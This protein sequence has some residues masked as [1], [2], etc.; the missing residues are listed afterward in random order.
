[1]YFKRIEMQG[2]KS[3][4]EPVTIEFTDGITCIV[5]PNGSG[6]SNISDAIRWVLGEQSPKMLRG[7]K[8]EEVIFAG[9][10]SRKSRGMAEVTLVIDNSTGILDIDYN[11]VAITRR[12]FRSG[13][14]EYAINNNQCRLRD[15]RNLIMDTG[16]GV[17]GYSII[18]Q[19]KI[20][21]IISDKP[22]SRREIFEEAAGI[23]TYRTKK[24]ESERKLAASQA[25]LE[26]VE[27]IVKELE[28]RIPKLKSDSE[29]AK[30][31]LSL[32]ERYKELEINITLKNV[33]KIE[34]QDE[35]FK[36][37]IAEIEA[38]LEEIRESRLEKEKDAED[39]RLRNETLEGIA[40]ETKDKLIACVESINNAVSRNELN[41]AKID[42]IDASRE[43][44]EGEI[45]AL[46]AK[47]EREKE[48]RGSLE[49]T[50]LDIDAKLEELTAVLTEKSNAHAAL[51][52]EMARAAADADSKK[53]EIFTLNSAVNAKLSEVQSIKNLIQTLDM[54]RGQVENDSREAETLNSGTLSDR[55]E[56]AE[57]RDAAEK[58]LAE[59]AEEG[60]KATDAYNSALNDERTL[61]RE[62]EET[63]LSLGRLSA[64]RKTFEEMEAN[65][66]GYNNAVKYI[67]KSGT[68][69]LRGVVAELITVP[70]G[71]E[72]AIETALGAALQNVVCEDDASAKE[73]ITKLKQNRAGRLTFLPITSVRPSS[74]RDA[75]AVRGSKGFLGFGTECVKYDAKY[76]NVMDYL[77]AR[78]AVVD[79]MDNATA[80]SK[81]NSQGLRIV[82]L[83][84]EVINASGA[85]TGG[86]YKNNTAN[87]LG[88]KAEIAK[89]AA[90]MT[91]LE[92]KRDKSSARAAELRTEME[93]SLAR[94]TELNSEHR[95]TELELVDLKNRLE[96]AELALNDFETAKAKR[97]KEIASI[98]EQKERAGADIER[99][100]AE[101]EEARGRIA[102]TESA[103]G[104]IMAGYDSRK[105]EVEAASEEITGA[106][107]NVSKCE[108]EK[109]SADAMLAR[110]T[111]DINDIEADITSRRN[112]LT[113]LADERS[114]ITD[115]HEDWAA[116]IAEKE[117]ERARIE[118]YSREI[119]EEKA[120]VFAHLTAISAEKEEIDKKVAQ[121]AQ[122]K[123]EIE[124]K[125]AKGEAQ[126]E[127]FKEKLWEEFEISYVQAIEMKKKDFSMSA[128]VKENREIK[129]R[130]REL[131][132]V[133]VG[134]IEEYASVSERYDF[135]TAQRADI[136]EA[137]ASLK[138]IIDDMDRTIISG[139]KTSFEEIQ[140]NFEEIFQ[141][142]FGGGIAKL[143]LEDENDPLGSG[144]EIT[145]QPPGKKLQNINLLS[146][147]EKTMT[148]IALMFAIL[149]T[150]PTP[151]CI[152]DEVE[153]ALD[154]ANIDRFSDY[155]KNFENIQFA[156]VT[157]QKATMAHADVLYG[158][159][160]PEQGISKVLSLR[161]GDEF[162]LN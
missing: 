108:S 107:I 104:A 24:A 126:L 45:E 3:F 43:R 72:V 155:L 79:N 158:V 2:F 105:A 101:A 55:K 128:A 117:E 37:D 162:E 12:M 136:L 44:L 111:A 109:E 56:L 75:A 85:I 100:N 132:E 116:V 14:S 35:Y 38:N 140:T 154:D 26:R 67:M 133:N 18:G 97:E 87:L 113:S 91:E 64:R 90:E 102:E 121:L 156:L 4:A 42:S 134:A 127:T 82:T 86:S 92:A 5:G 47:L 129:N 99:L 161:L 89:I 61:A 119:A 88:R 143:K 125:K 30:E 159:T 23:V 138:K 81:K 27:D 70:E 66:E 11:E 80:L 36:D 57:K 62:L 147:G 71:Y 95:K 139:F 65:Y 7:G 15:I 96:A 157:H 73:A 51:A 135:L 153:A 83:E 22:E 94:A 1:M 53:D 149:K 145:A 137:T 76:S 122:N 40:N 34:L 150:K 124:I 46:G 58:R 29:K 52:A 144:I 120:Q 103:V 77:L 123:Y 48:N 68:K 160:M 78:V 114:G 69:G 6:K 16:I 54:R 152:L 142:L 118:E 13:E 59:L 32:R 25:H 98:D 141:E 33:E 115:G 146:G 28:D 17:D 106:R 148:A 39:T 60:G 21:D 31:Y 93:K 131:G 84:G 9:T 110:V 10:A 19:G 74:V 130:I 20:A 151:F 41:K 49:K 112:E 63:R 50:K 8:M